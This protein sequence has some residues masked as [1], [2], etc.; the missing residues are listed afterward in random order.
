MKEKFILLDI[1][2]V[3]V[4]AASWKRIPILADGFYEFH[5]P[6]Q[7]QLDDLLRE[8]G[9]TIIITSTHRTRYDRLQWRDVFS[10]RL[11]NVKGIYTIDDLNYSFQSGNRLDEV[12]QWATQYGTDTPY[13]IID[14]DT[15]LHALPDPVKAHWVKTDPLI[16]LNKTTAAKALEILNA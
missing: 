12:L 9:A 3:M 13:V 5:A 14:D 4:S 7:E 6:A 15:A 1:D 10:K 11:T 2:G 8:S 16:G